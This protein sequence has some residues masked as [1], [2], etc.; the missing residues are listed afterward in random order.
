MNCKTRVNG[1]TICKRGVIEYK[2]VK[3]KT[4]YTVYCA[5]AV[6]SL[7]LS[8]CCCQVGK[9]WDNWFDLGF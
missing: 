7:K 5:D 6:E 2:H 9:K 1:Y 4:L 8:A 3:L